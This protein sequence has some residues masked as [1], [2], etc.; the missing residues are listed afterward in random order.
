MVPSTRMTLFASGLLAAASGLS[1]PSQTMTF[2]NV[3]SRVICLSCPSRA[4]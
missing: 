3:W 1:L 4:R 2:S